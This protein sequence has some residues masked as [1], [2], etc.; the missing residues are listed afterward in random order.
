MRLEYSIYSRFQG[1]D[2]RVYQRFRCKE[3]TKVSLTI[4]AMLVDSIA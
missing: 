4:I 1:Q 2:S 3:E